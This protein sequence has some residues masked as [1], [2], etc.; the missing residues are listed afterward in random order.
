MNIWIHY[1]HHIA[2]PL[3]ENSYTYVSEPE[4]STEVKIP[5][6]SRSTECDAKSLTANT[7]RPKNNTNFYSSRAT[8]LT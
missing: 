8:F 6:Y 7:P 1:S 2:L 4:G 5:R 3:Y